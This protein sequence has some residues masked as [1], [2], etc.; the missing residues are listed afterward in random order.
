MQEFFATQLNGQP[1]KRY[2]QVLIG[3]ISTMIGLAWLILGLWSASPD[4]RW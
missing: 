2:D 1:A 4:G 3:L